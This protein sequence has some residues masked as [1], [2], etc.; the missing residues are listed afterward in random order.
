MAAMGTGSFIS[1]YFQKD[2]L[3]SFISLEI[4]LGFLGGISVPSLY[5]AFAYTNAYQIFMFSF[6]LAIGILIG[7]EIPILTRLMD[8]HY[9]LRVNISNILSLDYF[10]ALLATLLFPFILLP[11]AG[12]FKSSLIFG[13]INM[14]IGFFNL[15]VF[16]D[17]LKISKKRVCY[18]A[19]IVVSVFLAFL[20][21]SAEFILKDWRGEVFEDRVV[22]ATQSNYQNLTLTKHKNDIRLYLNGALQFSSADEYRYH[23]SLIHIPLNTAFKRDRILILGGGD[24]LAVREILKYSDVYEIVLVDLDPAVTKL[25][26]TNA[27]LLKLNK[28]SLINNKV[29]VINNDA[30]IFLKNNRKLF[31]IIIADLPDPSNVSVARLY[32]LEFYLFV[33]KNL[34]QRGI[35]L[36]QATSPF[37]ANE[38]FWCI[39]RTIKKAGL[40]FTKPYHLN[41]PSFAEWGFV[42]ASR[43]P[44]NIEKINILVDTRYLDTKIVAKHFSFAKDLTNK[45]TSFSSLE[46]PQVLKYY[47]KELKRWN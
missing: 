35:F 3:A 43:F 37:F 8:K 13:L 29:T 25:A 42:M 27:H 7:L 19:S 5:L 18:G 40:K 11:F 17:E 30:F 24:G 16:S 20:I 28:K 45:N 46:S 12:T 2:L 47:L 4:L 26:T 10:G 15:Y 41:I 31:D 36:T 21:Y 6:I 9:S 22:Y 39:N 23:E 34:S 38:T 32:S 33:K 44:L 1:R 14:S